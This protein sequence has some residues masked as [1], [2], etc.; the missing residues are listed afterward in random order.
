MS[1][2]R[3]ITRKYGIQEY[4]RVCNRMRMRKVSTNPY[5]VHQRYAHPN[6]TEFHHKTMSLSKTRGFFF[7]AY[8]TCLIIVLVDYILSK[9]CFKS[10]MMSST[11]SIPTLQ[12]DNK[13]NTDLHVTYHL[14]GQHHTCIKAFLLSTALDWKKKQKKKQT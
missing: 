13:I 7:N 8:H 9:A 5:H 4:G 10:L 1:D 6:M 2:M 12:R 3:L 11:F 14:A